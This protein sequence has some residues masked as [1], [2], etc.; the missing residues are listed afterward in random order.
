MAQDVQTSLRVIRSDGRFAT[1]ETALGI[2]TVPQANVTMLGTMVT[3]QRRGI[4]DIN[5]HGVR[6]GDVV[7]DCGANVGV[8]AR[9]AL[10]LG[11]AKVVAVE[12][13]PDSVECLRRNFVSEIA[14]GKLLVYPKGVWD[15]ESVL[16]LHLNA[17]SWADSVAVNWGG[18]SIKVPLTTIDSLV[19]ELNLERVDFIKMDIEGAERQALKGARETVRR[20]HPRMAVALEH[21]AADVDEIPALIRKLWPG[22]RTL[23]GP[24]ALESPSGSLRVQPQVVA[25]F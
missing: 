5:G 2:F 11:A 9:H 24:C 25:A 7:L 23:C 6:Y 15:T 1:V 21:L 4:Y 3:E 22:T 16:D 10:L 20:H 12:P 8:Y 13:A 18:K 19:R 14:A 17:D